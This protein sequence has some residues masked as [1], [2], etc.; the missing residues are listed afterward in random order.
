MGTPAAGEGALRLVDAREECAVMDEI[1]R[2]GLDIDQGMVVKKDGRLYYGS[3][4]IN[5]LARMSSRADFFNELT[6]LTFRS[7]PV[8]HVLY[9]VSRAFRNLFLKT[10]RKTKINN[11]GVAG[12]E[13]F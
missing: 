3:D 7:R 2:A 12:N 6:H 1:T 8:A 10:L 13:R 4:A 5:I 11:L 9:P